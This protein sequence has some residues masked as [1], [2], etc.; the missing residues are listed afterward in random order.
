MTAALVIAK[1]DPEA[2]KALAGQYRSNAAARALFEAGDAGAAR[3]AA[4]DG[5]FRKFLK[6][7]G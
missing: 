3:K 4:L 2:A 6:A 5:S 1:T 7:G